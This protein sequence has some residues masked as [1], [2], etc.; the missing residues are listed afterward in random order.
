M[1]HIF[2]TGISGYIAARLARALL[3]DD[4]VEKVVGIDIREP[5]PAILP[6]L[7]GLVFVQQDVRE[8]ISRI[9]ADHDIDTIVHTAWVLPPA[10]DTGRMED[11]NVRGS[12]NILN[13]AAASGVRQ[14]LYTSSATAYGFHPDNEIPVLL[15]MLLGLS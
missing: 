7:P 6:A 4:R 15:G 8:N 11:I 3:A 10:H 13:A 9:L 14:I 1:K 2:I 5:D 12:L